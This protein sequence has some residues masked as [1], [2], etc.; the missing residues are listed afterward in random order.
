MH[1][2]LNTKFPLPL[3][4]ATLAVLL[5][6]AGCAEKS[7]GPTFRVDPKVPL[8]EKDKDPVG[9]ISDGDSDFFP[10]DSL[11]SYRMVC[12]S[13]RKPST[14]APFVYIGHAGMSKNGK[15]EIGRWR[16]EST[17]RLPDDLRKLSHVQTRLF[18]QVRLLKTDMG[19]IPSGDYLVSLNDDLFDNKKWQVWTRLPKLSDWLKA[20]AQRRNPDLFSHFQWTAALTSTDAQP[21]EQWILPDSKKDEWTLYSGREAMQVQ[22]SL[23]SSLKVSQSRMFVFDGQIFWNIWNGSKMS[24]ATWDSEK[25]VV[26]ISAQ[27]K[28]VQAHQSNFQKTLFVSKSAQEGQW[29][30]VDESSKIL[31]SSRELPVIRG[32]SHSRDS[33]KVWLTFDSR[34]ASKLELRDVDF[35]VSEIIKLPMEGAIVS[36]VTELA[37]HPGLLSVGIL[38]PR[39]RLN[40]A[41]VYLL[42]VDSGTWRGSVGKRHCANPVVFPKR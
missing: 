34:E 36:S 5:L 13:Y 18:A 28:W 9:G 4:T 16:E 32:L 1:A 31:V 22:A 39:T 35:K 14:N 29:D 27:E 25:G 11:A 23:P 33:K 19:S 10:L 7:S 17:N 12:E 2:P 3:A 38:P 20:P 6:L 26:E 21:T 15:W 37:G 30:L 8:T 24:F 42:H 41:L 40:K